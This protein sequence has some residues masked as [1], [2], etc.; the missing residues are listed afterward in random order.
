MNLGGQVSSALPALH[1]EIASPDMYTIPFPLLFVPI[2][3]PRA[4]LNSVP[5]VSNLPR[6]F[7]ET[8]TCQ[9]CY[10][11]LSVV[12]V[13]AVCPVFSLCACCVCRTIWVLGVCCAWVLLCITVPRSPAPVL[14]FL[15]FT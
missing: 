13:P 12:F 6:L 1:T 7:T 4:W 9:G 10:F 15:H 8:P 2:L 3:V 14:L 5:R 11:V